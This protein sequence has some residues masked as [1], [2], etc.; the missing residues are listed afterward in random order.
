[1]A[2]KIYIDLGANRGS[3][4]RNFR[5]ENADFIVFG[6]E[7]TPALVQGLRSEFRGTDSNVHIMEYAAWIHDGIVNFYFGAD[8]DQSSTAIIGKRDTPGWQIDYK[9]PYRAAAIDFDRWF[10]E[11][12][13]D[14]DYIII[15]MDVEGAEYKLLRR[16][17]DS[18]SIKRVKEARIEWHWNRYPL[19]VTEAQHNMLREQLAAITNVVDWE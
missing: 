16:M 17:L 12:T 4:I 2:R 8:S 10:R 19:E 3:T 6:F 18:G 15:K 7:P 9:V 11:N 14:D 13:S 1:M 5:R